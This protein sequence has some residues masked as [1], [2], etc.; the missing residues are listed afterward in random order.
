MFIVSDARRRRRLSALGVFCCLLLFVGGAFAQSAAVPEDAPVLISEP[1]STRALF[2][3][4]NGKRGASLPTRVVQPG[5]RSVVTFYL[6]NLV[7]MLEGEG[8]NA[9]RAELEDA[10]HY[11]YPL[12]IVRFERTAE[13]K[14]VYALSVRLGGEIGSV[15]DVLVRVTWRGMSSNRVRLAIGFEGGKIQDDEG[16]APT[17]MPGMQAATWKLSP[18]RAALPWTGDRVRFM[19]QATFGVNAALEARLRRIG[20]STWLEEQMDEASFSTFVYPNFAPVPTTPSSTCDGDNQPADVPVTCFR[21]NYTMY[22]L[23]NWF[24]KE[25]L[26]NENQQLRRRV[27]WA[28]SQVLVTSGRNI[29]QPSRMM[30]YVQTIDRHAF[31]NFRTLMEEMTLNPAMGQYLDMAISTRT[32]PNENYAREILQLFSIGVDLLNQDGTPVLDNQGNR[33]PSYNQEIINNFTKVF[34]GW[35]YCQNPSCQNWQPGLVNFRDSM[36]VTPANHDPGAKT[37]LN[38]PGATPNIPAGLSPDDDLEAA[39]NNI[40]YHPNVAPFISKLLIKQ[41]VT[42]NP[43]PAYVGRVAA[44]FNNNGAGTRGDLKAVIRAILLDPEARGNVK[45]DPDYGKLREPVL[46]I[47]SVLRPFNPTAN[48]NIGV[49]ASCNG[50]SDGV[51]NGI[52]QPL[53]QDVFNA[54]N[55]F[56]YYSMEYIIPGTPLNGPEFGIFSTGTAL[57]RPNFIN[58]MSPPGSTSATAGILAVTGSAANPTSIPCGTRIDLSRLQALAAADTTGAALVDTLNRE[59]MHGSMSAAVRNDILTAVQAVASTNTLKRA[60]TAYYLVTTLTQYQVQR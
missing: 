42:S 24:Y 50:Q 13:R 26:Y 28:L 12:E 49:P 59:L 27:S 34:T 60:R 8:A 57:K 7:D 10:N 40:F 14:Q 1:G 53:D 58:Q 36:I 52:S 48:N 25:A 3:L 35:S 38:Y 29:V 44:V 30:P 32:N 45:T 20:Y 4:A 16:A 37:L 19:E 2:T 47:T 56:N 33:I 23:Q 15:G 5:N 17:P 21:D 9:F 6:T 31:G 43:T 55:V 41:L 22:P 46:Y 54:P 18:N 51:I 39:L 11:R